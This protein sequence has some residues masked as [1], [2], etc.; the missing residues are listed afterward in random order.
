MAGRKIIEDSDEED[1]DDIKSPSKVATDVSP[2][3]RLMDADLSSLP[4]SKN[5]PNHDEPST[6]ST[7]SNG[8]SRIF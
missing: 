1:H 2:A 3:S 6:G 7:G 4:S 8:G 5:L